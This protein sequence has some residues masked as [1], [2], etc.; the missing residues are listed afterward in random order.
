MIF[1]QGLLSGIDQQTMP[2]TYGL[3]SQGGQ[4]QP[5]QSLIERG[6]ANPESMLALGATLLQA[7]GQGMGTGEGLGAGLQAFS[8][9]LAQAEAQK[10][11]IRSQ[12]IEDISKA[13]QA[14]NLLGGGFAGNSIQAQMATMQMR[15]YIAQGMSPEE[16]RY[17]AGNDVMQST[18][19]YTTDYATGATI[20]VPRNPMPYVG[21]GPQLQNAGQPLQQAPMSAPIA[22]APLPPVSPINSPQAADDIQGLFDPTG[23]AP[24]VPFGPQAMNAPIQQPISAPMPMFPPEPQPMQ[25]P[26]QPTTAGRNVNMTPVEQR[27]FD[28]ANTED[29]VKQAAKIRETASN[30]V[31]LQ[32]AAENALNILDSGFTTGAQADLRAKFNSILPSKNPTPEETKF[33]QDYATVERYFGKAVMDNLKNFT[34]A[35]SDGERKY[36]QTLAGSTSAAPEIL[37]A[38]IMFDYMG[39]QAAQRKADFAD[40]WEARYGSLNKR[41]ENNKTFARALSDYAESNPILTPEVAQRFGTFYYVKDESETGSLP[42]GLKV[43]NMETGKYGVVK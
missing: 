18:P 40:Q 20:Q 7:G 5:Q 22:S 24:I 9:S 14:D 43:Y 33:L 10:Q 1:D 6:L 8:Q 38:K 39:A 23:N 13:A 35:I 30:A 3:L 16:A 26:M 36:S 29:A 42:K 28:T 11:K 4:A 21:L 25:T 2:I 12:Q 15:R 41:D 32:Q 17:K 34:G 19:Q 37:R 27:A 31:E